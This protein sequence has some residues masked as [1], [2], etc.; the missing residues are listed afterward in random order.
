MDFILLYQKTVMVRGSNGE[1]SNNF[2]MISVKSSVLIIN[3]NSEEM[4]NYNV[5]PSL[6]KR[7]Y[8][9]KILRNTLLFSVIIVSGFFNYENALAQSLF[10]EVGEEE[11]QGEDEILDLTSSAVSMMDLDL[12]DLTDE[13]TFL[14]TGALVPVAGA[15]AL[16]PGLSLR[17]WGALSHVFGSTSKKFMV[18]LGV[19]SAGIAKAVWQVRRNPR[20]W[21]EEENVVFVSTP[22]RFSSSKPPRKL[23]AF[24][25]VE[26]L[27]KEEYLELTSSSEDEFQ[28]EKEMIIEDYYENL[29]S[30]ADEYNIRVRRVTG[31]ERY[32]IMADT[33]LDNMSELSPYSQRYFSRFLVALADSDLIEKKISVSALSSLDAELDSVAVIYT[34]GGC[35]PNPGLGGWAASL[36]YGGHEK[37]VAGSYAPKTTNKRMELTAIIEGLKC[38][39]RQNVGVGVY[40]TSGYVCDAVNMEWIKKWKRNGWRTIEGDDVKNQDLWLK[41]DPYLKKHQPLF[42]HLDSYR[43]VEGSKKLAKALRRSREQLINAKRDW[44]YERS[45]GFRGY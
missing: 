1:I 15:L 39:K 17:A 40:T 16:N 34:K 23:P 22:K 36:S 21:D 31:E 26:E 30:Y 29:R 19:A 33:V 24:F 18:I 25:A 2:L 8:I 5:K 9:L 6:A 11:R 27:T 10:V 38:L 3:V 4:M 41:L 43:G 44:P 37:L 14:V 42:F 13:E 28:Y 12:E 35:S 20:D 45:C 32:N 7:W